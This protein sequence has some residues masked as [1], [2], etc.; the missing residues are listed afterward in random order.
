MKLKLSTILKLPNKLQWVILALSPIVSFYLLEYYT[1]NPFKTMNIQAQLLNIV[2]FEL[3][4]LLLLFLTKRARLGVILPA[5]LTA[6]AGLAN[7]FVLKFRSA[8][9]MPW[10]IYSIKTAASVADNFE[11]TLSKNAVLAL[12]GFFLIILL[13]ACCRLTLNIDWK[14]QAASAVLILLLLFGFTKMLH[15]DSAIRYF[16]LYDKLFTPTTMQYKDGTAV[17]FLM[18]LRFLSVSK[19]SGYSDSSAKE[20]LSSYETTGTPTQ[21]PNI[22]VIMDE[23]FSDLSVLGD[24]ETNQDYMPF[25]H[26]LMDG[27]ADTVSGTL[28]VSVLGGNTANTEFEFLTGNTMA[29]LPQGS[30]PYQQYIKGKTPTLASHLKGYGYQTAAMHPYHASGWERDQVYPWFGFDNSYFLDDFEHA[31]IVRKYVSDQANFE[32]IIDIYEQKD[33]DSPLFLFNVTMQNHSSYSEAYDNFHPDIELTDINSQALENYLSLIKLTDEAVEN[34]ISYFQTQEEETILVFFGDHQPTNFIADPILR[35]HG[36]TSDTLSDEELNLRY[37]VPFFIWANYDIEEA[38]GVETSVNYLGSRTL[39]LAGIPL[40]PYSA[41]LNELK[42]TFPVITSM[43]VTDSSGKS[44]S[45][46][47]KLPELN[48]YEILQYYMLFGKK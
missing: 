5:L 31:E 42:E 38:S 21:T 18:E 17:A 47:E 44:T 16:K 28:N 13:G 34:L 7:Y 43:Q 9:I 36:K 22:I 40:D 14:K 35:S 19:P 3:V 48:T 23:A 12:L 37:S 10:D 27:A 29:F 39:K 33:T 8:P 41:Y 46:K 11:Y 20:L 2:F 32:K 15:Q 30:V 45:V 24:F 4:M 25:I 26:S 6:L 1:R